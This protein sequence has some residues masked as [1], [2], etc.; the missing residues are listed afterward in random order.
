M[1]ESLS[2]PFQKIYHNLIKQGVLV[3]FSSKLS[4]FIYMAKIYEISSLP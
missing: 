1:E 3:T 2:F 4:D